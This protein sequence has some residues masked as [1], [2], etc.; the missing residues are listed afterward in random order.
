MYRLLAAGLCVDGRW[1]RCACISGGP[2][3][4]SRFMDW[5]FEGEVG[6]EAEGTALT[7]LRVHSHSDHF[8]GSGPS[9]F[10]SLCFVDNGQRA[11]R[12]R[13]FS[14]HPLSPSLACANLSL[15]LLNSVTDSPCTHISYLFPYYILTE[16]TR[17]S[18]FLPMTQVSLNKLSPTHGFFVGC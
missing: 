1:V 3:L 13:L 4:G 18:T 7:L 15:Q 14:W 11:L 6:L 2:G 17:T 5:A 8:S 12:P 16:S 9:F 10:F